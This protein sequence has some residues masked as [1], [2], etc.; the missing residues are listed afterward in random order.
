MVIEVYVAMSLKMEMYVILYDLM[1]VGNTCY[2][3]FVF[4]DME[5]EK[6]VMMWM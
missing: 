4:D 1:I 6:H 2:D 5:L 3:V